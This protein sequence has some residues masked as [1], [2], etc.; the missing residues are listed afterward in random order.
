MFV[1]CTVK[2][3]NLASGSG[4]FVD[5][6]RSLYLCCKVVQGG[7]GCVDSGR[8]NELVARHVVLPAQTLVSCKPL[9]QDPIDFEP[10]HLP[11]YKW[12]E[13]SGQRQSRTPSH[14]PTALAQQ[15]NS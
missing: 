15:R 2:A 8:V 13:T 1:G 14:A 12:W 10:F 9:L 3:L 11:S 6:V 5:L 7:I 4:A